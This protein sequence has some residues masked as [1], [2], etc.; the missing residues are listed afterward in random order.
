MKTLT[1][2]KAILTSTSVAAVL[3]LSGAQAFA[4]DESGI[5]NMKTDSD[6][7]NIS[8]GKSARFSVNSEEKAE[9]VDLPEPQ[10]VEEIDEE[11]DVDL[12]DSKAE[13]TPSKNLE[14]TVHFAFDSSELSES[15]REKLEAIT[16]S[17][18]DGEYTVSIDGYADPTGDE[19]YN[20]H[21]SEK[22]ADAVKNALSTQLDDDIQVSWNVEG[23]GELS[24]DVLDEDDMSM[25]DARRVVIRLE[26]EGSEKLSAR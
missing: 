11:V 5:L 12:V 2:Y 9:N 10:I 26:R 20:Q 13:Y 17:D 23:H 25:S 6:V 3:A 24:E 14:T 16:L 4:E 8:A 22:R 19:Q 18:A 21:L 15:E 1:K 7:R